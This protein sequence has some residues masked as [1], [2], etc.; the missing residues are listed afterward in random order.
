MKYP[1]LWKREPRLKPDGVTIIDSTLGVIV[2]DYVTEQSPATFERIAEAS[3][4]DQVLRWLAREDFRPQMIY[5]AP[6]DTKTP[7]HLLIFF[8]EHP[9]ADEDTKQITFSGRTWDEA[10]IPACATVLDARAAAK[11]THA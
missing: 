1:V 4:R 6:Y 5:A 8:P 2:D 11:P 9:D 7:C 3:C 10:I